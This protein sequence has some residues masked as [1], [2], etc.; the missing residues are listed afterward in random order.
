M[1]SHT[2]TKSHKPQMVSEASHSLLLLSDS[3]LP[4]GSFA[5]SSGLESYIANIRPQ[6]MDLTGVQRFVIL[7]LASTSSTAIPYVLAAW[8]EPQ[9]LEKLDND[10]DA[11]TLCQVARRASVAQ[12]R[13]LLGV[14][15]RS[16]A[17]NMD[18]N[19]ET[20]EAAQ[21]LESFSLT[22][23]RA[24]S[25]EGTTQRNHGHLP[26]MWGA[27]CRAAAVPLQT[28]AYVFLFKHTQ[29]VLS[30]AVRSSVIGPYQA[31]AFLA[32][33]WLQEI[34]IGALDEEWETRVEEAGQSVPLMDIWMGLHDKLYSRVFNA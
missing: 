27:V 4:L 19:P 33:G 21:A 5:F 32:S 25:Q 28:A 7:S 24:R 15:E 14:W 18:R 30:A 17:N 1:S 29:S 20:E 13:A 31:Q 6:R 12:G 26:V 2:T 11:S 3:A 16:L 22:G 23:R 34:L 10:L 9:R 8:Q